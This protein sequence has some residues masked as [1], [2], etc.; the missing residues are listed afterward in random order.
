MK[1][2]GDL[3]IERNIITKEDLEKTLKIQAGGPRRLGEIL[4]SLKL[5]TEDCLVDVLSEQ[6]GV[7]KRTTIFGLEGCNAVPYYICKKYSVYPLNVTDNV[8]N[9]AM[10]DPMDLE[11]IVAV[12]C[13]TGYTVNPFLVKRDEIESCIKSVPFSMKDIINTD[14]INKASKILLIVLAITSIV[15]L[16]IVS[17]IQYHKSNGVETKIESGKIYENLDLTVQITDGNKVKFMGHGAYS[18][19]IF[20]VDLPGR[21]GLKVFVDSKRE[22]F[23]KEQLEWMEIIINNK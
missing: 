17:K 3:L 1:K 10:L 22:S 16:G 21:D 19:G 15:L 7:A 9:L 2:L 14:N 11:A 8:I 5:I 20:S 4:V 12:E 6:P 13:E 23:S 18:K